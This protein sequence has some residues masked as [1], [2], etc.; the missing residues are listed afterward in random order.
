MGE[1]ATSVKDVFERQLP[2]RL[3]GKPD[4]VA[5]INALYQFNISGPEGG[6]WAVDCTAPGGK[7]TAGAAPAARCTVP[8]GCVQSTLHDP[9]PGPEML[10]W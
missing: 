1:N 8:P 6:S 10:N 3:A 5:K 9:P 4:V 7:I 2:A